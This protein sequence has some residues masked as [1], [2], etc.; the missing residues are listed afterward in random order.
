L[1]LNGLMPLLLAVGL[2]QD[3]SFLPV[4]MRTDP[5]ALTMMVGLGF[6]SPALNLLAMLRTPRHAMPLAA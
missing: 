4:M 5:F 6:V 1:L 2:V 3:A